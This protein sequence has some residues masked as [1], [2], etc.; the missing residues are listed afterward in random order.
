MTFYIQH[1]V[2]T[3]YDEQIECVCVWGGGGGG[4]GGLAVPLQSELGYGQSKFTHEQPHDIITLPIDP[5]GSEVV[6]GSSLK[7]N[8]H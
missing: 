2:N 1:S 4:G 3:N 8:N 7:I 6:Q 5:Q